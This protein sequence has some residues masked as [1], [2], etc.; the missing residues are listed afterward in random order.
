[1]SS[2]CLITHMDLHIMEYPDPALYRGDFMAMVVRKLNSKLDNTWRVKLNDDGT[3]RL[4]DFSLQPNQKN[5]PDAVC[6]NQVDAPDW[7]K[8][9]L[10]ILQI[11]EIG[12]IVDSVGQRVSENV[13][14]VIN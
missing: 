7:V 1:M 4:T 10:A 13:Y 14:Y 9:K 5:L 3:I 6:L 8:S 11:C 2:D 12:T